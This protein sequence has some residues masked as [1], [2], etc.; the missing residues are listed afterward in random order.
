MCPGTLALVTAATAIAG[1][2]V[3][4]A[5]TMYSG[6]AAGDAASYQAQVAKNNS[7][8]AEQNAKYASEAGAAQA[9]AVSLKGAAKMG[10]IKT[11]QAADNIDVNT[12]SAVNVRASEREAG[13]LDTATVLSNAELESYGYRAKATG[14]TAESGLLQTQAEEA[15][16]GAGIGAT[17]SLLSGASSV[18][19]KFGGSGTPGTVAPGTVGPNQIPGQQ[20]T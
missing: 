7:L 1:A 12:G 2:G 5:G 19:F 9:T 13:V 4:A 18:G 16:I 20:F 6:M 10:K 8:I 15:P 3:S 14:Y 17:G 11:A